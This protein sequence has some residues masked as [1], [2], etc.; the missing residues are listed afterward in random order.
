VWTNN[1]SILSFLYTKFAN[2]L[3]KYPESLSVSKLL[4]KCQERVCVNR[5]EGEG[6]CAAGL[7]AVSHRAN[8]PW[9]EV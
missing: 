4:P 2:L 3:L 5:K 7:S 1:E 8:D 6:S 9:R